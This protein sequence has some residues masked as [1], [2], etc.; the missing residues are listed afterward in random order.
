MAKSRSPLALSSKPLLTSNSLLVFSAARPLMEEEKG[1]GWLSGTSIFF[2]CLESTAA[3]PIQFQILD[4]RFQIEVFVYLR[5]PNSLL[6]AIYSLV[7]NRYVFAPHR[8]GR[9]SPSLH[10]QS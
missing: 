9:L 7:R 3:S 10:L 4:C 5:T 6:R 2:L 1:N 8:L